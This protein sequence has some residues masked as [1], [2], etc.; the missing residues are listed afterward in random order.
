MKRRKGTP[1]T[2]AELKRLG[3]TA[4]SVLARCIGRTIGENRRRTRTPTHQI[5]DWWTAR[6]TKL[7][8]RFNDAELARRLR[9]TA[10]HARRQRAPMPMLSLIPELK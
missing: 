10:D 4:D 3:K 5:G 6:E 7:T 1:G 9:R 2:L 8:G